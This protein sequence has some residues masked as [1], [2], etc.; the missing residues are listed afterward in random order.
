MD[1]R[2]Q[3]LSLQ[4]LHL[5]L[6]LHLPLFS[7]FAWSSLPPKSSSV[8]RVS[9][10][11]SSVQSL[12]ASQQPLFKQSCFLL[13]YSFQCS[14]NCLTHSQPVLLSQSVMM[15]IP[16]H[17]TA[18]PSPPWH[19]IALLR[20]GLVVLSSLPDLSA[21]TSRH[22]V[23]HPRCPV[24][25]S[26]PALRPLVNLVEPGRMCHLPG[27]V[28]RSSDLLFPWLRLVNRTTKPL[29]CLFP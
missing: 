17:H 27:V 26:C 20:S 14:K 11:S 16:G 3:R 7:P 29:S 10:K 19:T 22:H 1:R 15:A 9:P 24:T 28:P 5:L 12:P 2:I 6:Q 4:G 18:L 8:D 25:L 23:I 13:R 21:S